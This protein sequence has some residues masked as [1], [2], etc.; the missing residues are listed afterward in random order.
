MSTQ[1]NDRLKNMIKKYVQDIIH[2][3]ERKQAL[4]GKNATTAKSLK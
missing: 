4:G 1:S 2:N 3:F